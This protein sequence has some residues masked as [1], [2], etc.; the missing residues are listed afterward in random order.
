MQRVGN[1]RFFGKQTANNTSMD[2]NYKS[3]ILQYSQDKKD[4][5]QRNRYAG[6]EQ[7]LPF[8]DKV[9]NVLIG[10]EPFS[11]DV[12]E[13][14]LDNKYYPV[15][16][17]FHSIVSFH[18]VRRKD[19]FTNPWT[20]DNPIIKK[21]VFSKG[22]SPKERTYYINSLVVGFWYNEKLKS[23]DLVKFLKQMDSHS[24]ILLKQFAAIPQTLF[25]RTFLGTII[26][27]KILMLPT[28]QIWRILTTLIETRKNFFEIK[29][30]NEY[31][32]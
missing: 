24:S 30:E 15:L 12:L 7:L 4:Y 22:E 32:N 31:K 14:L 26:K 2:E 23:E 18:S 13:K 17:F 28:D 3:H 20:I 21:I 19:E 29:K 6:E 16:D 25:I 10:D 1:L 27:K 8:L 11:D 9:T 5:I